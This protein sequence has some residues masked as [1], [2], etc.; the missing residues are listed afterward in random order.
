MAEPILIK[1]G[2]HVMASEP[3]STED[4]I[5]HFHN[6]ASLCAHPSYRCYEKL[7]S[8]FLPRHGSVKTFPRQRIQATTELLDSPF[9]MHVS[10][11]VFLSLLGNRSVKTF[12]RQRI[13]ATTELLDSPFSMHVSLFVFLPLLGNRSVKTF[14]RQRI[15]VEDFI[16]YAVRD[17]SKKSKRLVSPTPFNCVR[18]L[19][20]VVTSNRTASVV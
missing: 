5:N 13:Q 16:S 8:L 4:F 17:V 18:Y 10:L 14:L 19:L 2:M 6:S 11:F 3:I 1:L 20:F 12:P 9:S 15:T 7:P